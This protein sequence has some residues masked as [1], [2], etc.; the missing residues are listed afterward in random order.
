LAE[1]WKGNLRI[2]KWKLLI[3]TNLGYPF[4]ETFGKQLKLILPK[5]ILL[6]T[7]VT[8]RCRPIII[9]LFSVY[10][11]I[12]LFHAYVRRVYWLI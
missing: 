9:F 8:R 2:S 5:K 1:K 10:F 11:G 3:I 6:T 7:N 12:F 4:G